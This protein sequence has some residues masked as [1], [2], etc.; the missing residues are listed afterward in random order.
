MKK[1]N[2]WV[3]AGG[4]IVLLVGVV[5]FFQGLGALK[6]SPMTGEIFWSYMGAIVFILGIAVLLRGLRGTKRTNSR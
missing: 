5:W 6:G 4:V 2:L 3:V 1:R